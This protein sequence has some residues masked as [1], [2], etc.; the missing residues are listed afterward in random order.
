[1]DMLHVGAKLLQDFL[2]GKGNQD[3]IAKALMQLIGEK[4]G[5]LDVASLVARLSSNSNVQGL[6]TS[7]L[8]DG[9]NDAIDPAQILAIF[10][11]GRVG[12]FAE[13]IG[14]APD[15]AAGG[16]AATLPQMIEQFSRGGSLLDSAGGVAGM[17]GMAKKFF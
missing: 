9:G 6:V 5:Q 12:A 4:E 2:G 16:L 3:V 14:V 10:G 15:Q 11:Q 1:M 17:F 13:Q 7:W 8:S